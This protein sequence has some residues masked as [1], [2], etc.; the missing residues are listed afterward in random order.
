MFGQ[1][2]IFC[3]YWNCNQTMFILK[4][5]NQK[6]NVIGLNTST[7]YNL[8]GSASLMEQS[9]SLP[10]SM[11][12]TLTENTFSSFSYGPSSSSKLKNKTQKIQHV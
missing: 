12:I 1:F 5:T 8:P 6:K 4:R 9:Q 11:L 7:C 2:L 10:T 3:Q